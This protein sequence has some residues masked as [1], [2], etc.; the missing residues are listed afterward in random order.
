MARRVILSIVVSTVVCAGLASAASA[1]SPIRLYLNEG[2]AFRVL[3][4]SCGGI[5]QESYARGFGTNGYPIGNVHLQTRCGGSGR[6][7]G[8]HTTT[9]TGTASVVWTWFG[10]TRS[11]GALKGP[12]V[13]IS[14]QDS[15]G[16]KVYNVGNVAYLQTGTP[17]LRPPAPPTGV[18]ASF[19]LYESGESEFL[20]MTVGWTVAP[21]TAGLLKYSTATATPVNSNAP[22]LTTTVIP[23]FSS[24]ALQ[25][26]QP[27]TKYRVTVTSTDSEGTSKPSTPIEITSPNTDAEP[28]GS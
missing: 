22:V 4:H 16:D 3:G 14:A 27:G 10:E 23:Y 7:G 19:S 13:G 2:D 18:A 8:G 6:G 9:Y 15:H 12:L 28:G 21:E 11:Y 1:A 5:Q 24:A 26:V 25:P 17:P 20:R